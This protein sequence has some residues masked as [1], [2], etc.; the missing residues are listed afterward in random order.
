MID[1]KLFFQVL[2][3]VLLHP[4]I[5]QKLGLMLAVAM[6][7][8]YRINGNRK[9]MRM[10]FIFT[11]VYGAFFVWMLSSITDPAT[12]HEAL[13]PWTLMSSA[14]ILYTIGIGIGSR[15]AEYCRKKA[16][17]AIPKFWELT[18]AWQEQ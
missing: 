14:S 1:Y 6:V 7:A 2:G 12:L 17:N 4:G 8:G 10:L 15:A 3:E 5:L 13:I 9:Q 16:K 11:I 18:G